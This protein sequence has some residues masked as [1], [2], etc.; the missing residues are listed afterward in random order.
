MPMPAPSWLLLVWSGLA[1]TCA[2]AV[3]GSL[4]GGRSVAPWALVP[5]TRSRAAAALATLVAGVV[6][7]PMLYGLVFEV[8]GR[9]SAGTGLALGGIHGVAAFLAG[10]PR[11]TP[12][13]AVRSAFMHLLYG[14]VIAFLYVTP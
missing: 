8:L 2:A 14:V 13:P 4:F 11:T 1:A 10:S 7:Y 3:L 9:S 6:V 12:R 5:R